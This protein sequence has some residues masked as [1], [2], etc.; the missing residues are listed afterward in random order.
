[1]ADV[2][3]RVA[4]SLVEPDARD[5]AGDVGAELHPQLER[6]GV[7]GRRRSSVRRNCSRWSTKPLPPLE[8]AVVNDQVAG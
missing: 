4:C 6:A 1:M 3:A 8:A 5:V 7:V 2:G